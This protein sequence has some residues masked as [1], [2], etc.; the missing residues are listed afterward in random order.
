M[1]N[2]TDSTMMQNLN[3]L[4][5]VTTLTNSLHMAQ[6]SSTRSVAS[7]LL[8]VLLNES[9]IKDQ[10]IV[11]MP[12]EASRK[13]SI[14]EDMLMETLMHALS[15]VYAL[16]KALDAPP[17]EVTRVKG[18][19]LLS[20]GLQVLVTNHYEKLWCLPKPDPLLAYRHNWRKRNMEEA[21]SIKS[22]I[23]PTLAI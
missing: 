13:A 14:R 7:H 17:T 10:S 20:C 12:Q 3:T 4:R 19:I 18:P 6:S 11:P 8:E 16:P 1:N 15:C 21:D 5:N 9:V 22:C 23:E 2:S